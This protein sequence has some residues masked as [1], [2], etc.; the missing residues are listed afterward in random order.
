MK[1]RDGISAWMNSEIKRQDEELE[2]LDRT[3]KALKDVVKI[4]KGIPKP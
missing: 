3:E 2:R 1:Q 4:M